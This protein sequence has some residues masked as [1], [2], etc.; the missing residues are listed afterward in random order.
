MK[1]TFSAA[2]FVK[3]LADGTLKEA[4]TREGM[5]KPDPE[6][7]QAFLL[8]ED[9]SCRS[10]LKVPFDLI[11]KVEFLGTRPCKDH[12]HP[13]VRLHFK[14]PPKA[15]PLAALFAGLVRSQ[16]RLPEKPLPVT[17]AYPPTGLVAR[18][19]TARGVLTGPVRPAKPFVW[20]PLEQH[21]G[22]CRLY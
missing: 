21:S 9:G 6:D 19:G 20:T 18:P 17:P 3:A 22:D 1:T 5:A 7:S 11:E 2:E 13:F 8:S 16:S 10:W 15:N 14:E 12:K 4:V